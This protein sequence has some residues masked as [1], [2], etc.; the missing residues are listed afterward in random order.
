MSKG[1]N[2]ALWVVTVLLAGLFLM[3]GYGKFKTDPETLA[4]YAHWGRSMGFM[5]FIGA[6][7][8][9]GGIGLLVPRLATP[10]SVGLTIIMVGAVF[11][12]LR[13]G[14]YVYFPIPL[15]L[16]ILLAVVGYA[17]RPGRQAP[18]AA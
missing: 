17:R 10:A 18:A 12:H 16:I 3:T 9:A 5:R 13:A 1:K 11:T 15:V 2:V 6:C 4:I 8:L 14:E 7:E